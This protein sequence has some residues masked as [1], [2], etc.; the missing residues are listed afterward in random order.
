MRLYEALEF[1]H[2]CGFGNQFVSIYQPNGAGVMTTVDEAMSEY[3]PRSSR[4]APWFDL[5]VIEEP[6]IDAGN[7]WTLCVAYAEGRPASN[8]DGFWTEEEFL[9]LEQYGPRQC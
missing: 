4:V 1:M 3:G 5:P 9:A 6:Q 7:R 8:W 2:D